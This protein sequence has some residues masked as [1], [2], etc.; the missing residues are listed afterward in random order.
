L[1]LGALPF[2]TSLS[3]LHGSGKVLAYL[4][5]EGEFAASVTPSLIILDRVLTPKDGLA[6]LTEI[7][8]DQKLNPIPIIMMS[9]HTNNGVINE[10]YRL[11]VSSYIRK[12]DSLEGFIDTFRA[13]LNYWLIHASLPAI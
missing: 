7:K 10:A 6:L 11:G 3:V 4:R 12:P 8:R 5:K 9:G 13:L 1:V 2:K